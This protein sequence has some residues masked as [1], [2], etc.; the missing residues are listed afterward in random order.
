MF[1]KPLECSCVPFVEKVE[2]IFFFFTTVLLFCY[3]FETRGFS[4]AAFKCL[5]AQIATRKNQF[6]RFFGW[7]YCS[8]KRWKSS[9]WRPLNILLQCNVDFFRFPSKNPAFNLISPVFC[10]YFGDSLRIFYFSYNSIKWRS[11]VKLL[12]CSLPFFSEI[13]T[14]LCLDKE[15]TL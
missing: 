15:K 11:V 7:L 10:N 3:S 6:T 13:M 14:F 9:C 4:P 8:T 12:C 5:L 1:R 2:R